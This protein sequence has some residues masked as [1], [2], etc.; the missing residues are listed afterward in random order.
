[1]K[2]RDDSVVKNTTADEAAA[3]SDSRD[4]L[5]AGLTA[6]LQR[7]R[8]DFENYRKQMDLQKQQLATVVETKMVLKVLPLIDTVDLAIAQHPELEPVEKTVAKALEELGLTKI[9]ADVDTV[10][11]PS[12]HDAIQMD[13]DAEGETEVIAGVLRPGYMLGGEVIRPTLVRATKK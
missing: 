6:D 1:M 8:A 10:F 11:D 4:A 5:I 2:K 9:G 12:L 13:E 7:T 3:E